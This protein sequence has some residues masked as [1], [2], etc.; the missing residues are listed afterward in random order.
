[1]IADNSWLVIHNLISCSFS[2]CLYRT[3]FVCLPDRASHAISSSKTSF[4]FYAN[5]NP[6][7][8][9]L[10]SCPAQ[11]ITSWPV[12]WEMAH[13]CLNRSLA[14][15]LVPWHLLQ[16]QTVNTREPSEAEDKQR[17]PSPDVRPTPHTLAHR[18]KCS[19]Q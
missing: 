8:S 14:L 5:A 12:T 16:T 4:S 18:H 10:H 2:V 19:D 1:M 3:N 15:H 6:S 9:T 17:S 11:L 13:F 7:L